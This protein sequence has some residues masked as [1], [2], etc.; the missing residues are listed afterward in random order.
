[1]ANPLPWSP[2][3]LVAL[4]PG[5][6]NLTR[7]DVRGA[8]L[9]GAD[10]RGAYLSD[11]NRRN[12]NLSSKNFRGRDLSCC[13]PRRANLGRTNLSGSNFSGAYLG[14]PMRE[15][16][17]DDQREEVSH[18]SVRRV[19]KRLYRSSYAESRPSP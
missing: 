17:D 15:V 1:M 8:N 9:G 13:D 16:K 14:G 19:R 4:M 2:L 3:T 18:R 5:K 6:V 7:G 10:P 11:T 12:A